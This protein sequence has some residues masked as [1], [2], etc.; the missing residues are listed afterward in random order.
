MSIIKLYAEE[1]DPGV[2][3][4]SNVFIDYLL[5]D[6]NDAQLKVYLYLV[7][8]ISNHKP[9]DISNIADEFNH[10]QSDVIR[11]LKYWEDKQVLSLEY[12]AAGSITGIEL[13]NI[14][15]DIVN[16]R[17]NIHM[18]AIPSDKKENVQND[19]TVSIPETKFK[20][21]DFVEL[22]KN[23]DWVSIKVIAEN[24]L[25]RT[26]SA[27]DMQTL[28]H[29][30]KDF[31]FSPSDIDS[32]LDRCL[33][34]GKKTMRSIKKVAEEEYLSRNINPSI[35]AILNALGKQGAPC[36]EELTFINNWLEDM[37]L[38]LILE[39]CKKAYMSTSGNRFK[40]ANGIFN[41][42][43]A[44]GIKNIED[45]AREEEAFR[46][47]KEASKRQTAACRANTNKVVS[48]STDIYKQ[49]KHSNY[50]F[51]AL[52]REISMK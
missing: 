34:E 11:S 19:N 23:P 35:T 16:P 29:I 6:A 45:M 14:D 24:Y 39:G 30:Y 41:N 25:E 8:H 48:S 10:T 5:K 15:E 36:A 51:E 20:P 44:N 21:S 33:T 46:R 38:E 18:F 1:Y 49:Y 17:E 2:T 9:F 37:D 28:A 26:L 27:T 13:H 42:W 3:L 47:N 32:L 52:E 40:Y 4:I 50:D 43:K 12:D 7:R 31:A 22:S